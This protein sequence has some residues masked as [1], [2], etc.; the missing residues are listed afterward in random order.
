MFFHKKKQTITGK[1]NGQAAISTMLIIGGLIS[2]IALTLII[3]I[4]SY[5]SSSYGFQHSQRALAVANAGVDDA[6]IKLI[7]DRS[8]ENQTGYTVQVD[9]NTATVQVIQNSPQSGNVTIISTATV[10]NYKSRVRVVVS[11]DSNGEIRIVKRE[12]I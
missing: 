5:T 12:N 11:V 7:R 6:L 4:F 9:N 10:S 8:F 3:I 1:N 2:L